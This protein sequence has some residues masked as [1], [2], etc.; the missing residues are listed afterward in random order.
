MCGGII[1]DERQESR[2]SL[3]KKQRRYSLIEGQD[4][5][6]LLPC[7]STVRNIYIRSKELWRVL[8]PIYTL[9]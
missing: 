5:I 1:V 7:Y 8:K 2:D 4:L 3:K 9:K 6:L